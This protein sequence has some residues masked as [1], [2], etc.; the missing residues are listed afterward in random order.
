M[1]RQSVDAAKAKEILNDALNDVRHASYPPVHRKSKLISDV[2]LGSHL[3]YRYILI[4]NI[5]A[6]AT[7]AKIH[8]LA[9]QAGADVEGAFDSRSLCHTVIVEADRDPQGFAGRLGRSNEPYLNKPARYPTLST[10]NAVRRGNDRILLQKSIDVLE[11]LSSPDD[12]FTALKVAVYY[13]MQRGAMVAQAAEFYG[14]AQLPN[15]LVS[16]GEAILTTSCEGESCALLAA[17]SFYLY[18]G[19]NQTTEIKIHPVNQSGASSNETLDIDVFVSG[20]LLYAAEVKD[21]RFTLMDI[22]HAAIKAKKSGLSS[23]FFICGPQSS[24]ELAARRFGR[25][26]ATNGVYATT[27]DAFQFFASGVALMPAVLTAN[28][29]WNFVEKCMDDARFKDQTRQHVFD[30]A[31]SSGLI[32]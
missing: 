10:D 8:A 9:L 1:S 20:E 27:V 25:Q 12:A 11:F 4:T 7:N 32:K 2:I 16:F 21:K 24:G 22:D 23:F 30:S 14:A 18:C 3:T 28:E 31:E 15:V 29:I 13:T 5:L 6:K 19:A 17:L 26:M